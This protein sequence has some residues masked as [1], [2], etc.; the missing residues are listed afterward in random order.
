MARLV[1]YV[2]FYIQHNYKGMPIPVIRR[3]AAKYWRSSSPADYIKKRRLPPADPMRCTAWC[4]RLH[5][6][7]T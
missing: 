2:R 1:Y 3:T 5:A 7:V 6:T 4:H